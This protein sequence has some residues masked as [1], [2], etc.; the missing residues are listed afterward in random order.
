M[1][2]DHTLT[3][4]LFTEEIK[5]YCEGLFYMSESEY[6]LEPV[7]YEFP[8]GTVLNEGYVLNLVGQSPTAK[9]ETVALPY[10]FRNMTAEVPDADEDYTKN[11]TFRFRELQ[12]Y[13]LKNL[14]EVKVYRIGHREIQVYI[15]GKLDSTHL[16]GL[17][18]VAVE[19]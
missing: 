19:T 13:L 12:E 1:N 9:I 10:F 17:K 3:A 16:A 5:K 6:P 8:E 14:P 18:T 7:L 15:L 11:I 4:A 2:P